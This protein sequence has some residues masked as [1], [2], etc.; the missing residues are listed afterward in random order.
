MHTERSTD[1]RS[2]V[3]TTSNRVRTVCTATFLVIGFASLS[4][5][6]AIE[7]IGEYAILPGET[8]ILSSSVSSLVVDKLV[9][10][11]N[12]KLVIPSGTSWYLI[13][14]KETI[15]DRGSSI[16]ARGDNGESAVVAGGDGG[17]AKS[18]TDLVLFFGR[19]ASSG[20]RVITEGGTGGSGHAGRQGTAGSEASC[21]GS[22]AT[23]G[24]PGGDGGNAGDGGDGGDISVVIGPDSTGINLDFVSDGGFPGQVGAAGK[25]GPGGRG[26]NRCGPWPYWKKGA[27]PNGAPGNS[28]DPGTS[29]VDGAVQTC[30]D[31]GNRL[32]T[33]IE[34]YLS[35]Q[36]SKDIASLTGC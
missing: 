36:N 35:E 32:R 29:G 13:V 12:S 33:A 34:E 5:G 16:I 2:K 24:G 7:P 1:Q 21:L 25:G 31:Q 17:D 22:D 11:A 14:A 18:G 27:G 6:E 19:L 4:F 3:Q 9:L 30:I 28:G 15:A 20:L 8:R 26:K 23:G 10:G